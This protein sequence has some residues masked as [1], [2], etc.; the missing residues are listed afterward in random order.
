M[1]EPA[2]PDGSDAA[3]EMRRLARLYSWDM[4]VEEA[5]LW[6]GRLLRR[7]MDIGTLEDVL[8]MEQRVGRAALVEAIETASAGSLRPKS[9]AF[10]H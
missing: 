4:D 6:P 10:W 8:A 3:V 9:W 1:I 7:V 2:R 5:L